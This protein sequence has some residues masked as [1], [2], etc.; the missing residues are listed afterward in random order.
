ME[1]EQT[2]FNIDS[3]IL[4]EFKKKCID[5]EISYSDAVETLMKEYNKRK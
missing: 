4:K 3:E 2:A 1:K 5:N